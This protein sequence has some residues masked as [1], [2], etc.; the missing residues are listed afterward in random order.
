[1]EEISVSDVTLSKAL[2]EIKWLTENTTHKI[3]F[4]QIQEETSSQHLLLNMGCVVFIPHTAFPDLLM[5]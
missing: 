5:R 3:T 4:K 1:M 2:K